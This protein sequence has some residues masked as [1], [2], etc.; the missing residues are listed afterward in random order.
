MSNS[1]PKQ[2]LQKL[3]KNLV[4]D[5]P[6]ADLAWHDIRT[7]T[8]EG[9][10]WTQTDHFFDRLPA[11]AQALVRKPVWDLSHHTA[12][13][14]A[15]FTTNAQRIAA[16]WTLRFGNLAMDHMPATGVCGLDL[17]VMTDAGWRWVGVARPSRLPDNTVELVSG[18]SAGTR[19]YMLYL[20]LYNGIES[21]EIGLSPSAT[22][23]AMPT[24]S[25]ASGG[26]LCFYGTSITQGGCA[27]RPGMVYTSILGRRLDRPTINLG[28]SGNGLA[29]PELADL[30]AELD[31]TVYVIDSLANMKL[32]STRERICSM[33]C[34]LRAAHPHTPI[35]LVEFYGY[36]QAPCVLDKLAVGKDK[37]VALR[38]AF[39]E[40]RS[41][42][43]SDLHYV[44]ANGLIGDD[45][46]GT[47]DGIH[48][49]DLGYLR[50]ADKLEP[51]LR[52]LI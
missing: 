24:R 23:N 37:S 25:A 12:G 10:G 2:D 52:K 29:E 32:E 3:D 1:S 38:A 26:A 48:A 35:V 20:P 27:S 47:V 11:C 31:P 18:M 41:E 16:R 14:C 6:F 33:V 9:K 39:D 45:G 22:I 51:L 34:K 15:R 4:V 36:Q 42:S 44:T 49:T 43:I 21:L 8:I 13:I 28:F 46:E 50:M 5:Q 17:Y 19:Q 30:L 7:L 40:L